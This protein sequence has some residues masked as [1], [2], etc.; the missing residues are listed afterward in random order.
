MIRNYFVI[1]LRNLR[2]N[3]VYSLINIIGIS[4]GI[5][6]CFLAFFFV[7]D[8]LSYDRFHDNAERI[9][10]IRG[11]LRFGNM[12]AGV[13]AQ[14]PLGPTMPE[15]FPEVLNAVRIS[16]KKTVVKY[17]EKMFEENGLAV[18]QLIGAGSVAELEFYF[19]GFMTEQGFA[20]MRRFRSAA[21]KGAIQV[22]ESM[23]YAICMGLRASAFG[24]PFIPL[25]DFR[26]SDLL[27]IREEYQSIASP[28]NPEENVILVPALRP[29]VLLL[30]AH[31]ADK[32]GN[33]F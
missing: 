25:P 9:F 13:A 26:G 29:D 7:R 6:C 11:T 15:Q 12:L 21:E 27:T 24:I 22:K 18:D 14:P 1:A 30:H 19:L 8:E 16:S 28:Y 17:R 10:E 4:V 3:M 2:K 23:G 31:S 20:S 33:I 32:A 5:A